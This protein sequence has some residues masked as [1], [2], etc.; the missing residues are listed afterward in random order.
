[1]KS[2]IFTIL[3][4]AEYLLMSLPEH[5][6]SGSLWKSME[7]QVLWPTKGLLRMEKIGFIVETVLFGA[8]CFL[9]LLKCLGAVPW[10]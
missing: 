10:W 7:E 1:M 8:A 6:M 3:M 5:K 4:I 9:F 2:T